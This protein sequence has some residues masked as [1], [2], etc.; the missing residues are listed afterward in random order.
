MQMLVK[1]FNRLHSIIRPAQFG[2]PKLSKIT[3]LQLPMGSIYHYHQFAVREVGPEQ[4]DPIIAKQEKLS[5]IN[6]VQ[7]LEADNARGMPIRVPGDIKQRYIQ[8][9]RENKRIRKLLDERIVEKNPRTLFIENYAIL[10]QLWRY[11]TT[12]LS[13]YDKLYNV[14]N[15]VFSQMGR[16]CVR[17]NRQ[18]Y[19]CIALPNSLPSIVSLRR[20]E[21]VRTKNSLTAFSTPERF[22]FA[23][24]FCWLGENR[25][26]SII[27]KIGLDGLRRANIVL[28]Y[29]D[30]FVN[31]NLGELNLWRKNEA[32]VGLYTPENMQRRLYKTAISIITSVD[33]SDIAEMAD[34]TDTDAEL[35]QQ[36]NVQEAAQ[37]VHG[38]YEDTPLVEQNITDQPNE[39]TFHEPSMADQ[40]MVAQE[41]DDG[42]VV[43]DIDEE[44]EFT[45]MV[46]DEPNDPNT[47]V[48]DN[49]NITIDPE[50]GIAKACEKFIQAGM[51]SVKEHQRITQ[52]ASAYKSI[53]NPYGEGVLADM[54]EV[55]PEET[56]IE[57][58]KLF[59]SEI[60]ID[61]TVLEATT[62]V[63]NKKYIENVLPKDVVSSVVSIQRAGVAVSNYSK[64][65]IVDATGAVEEHTVSLAPVNGQ[66]V[67]VRFTLPKLDDR[68]YWRANDVKYT[69]RRQQ[70]DIPIRKVDYNTVALTTFY[71]KN[72][73][74]RSEKVAYDWSSWL[75][76]QIVAQGI[77]PSNV[78]ITNISMG[79]VF[80]QTALLPHDYC[81]IARRVTTFKSAGISYSFDYK[82]L[83]M[84][85]KEEEI[86]ELKEISCVPIGRD[87]QS[88]YG[89]DMLNNVYRKTNEEV[90]TVGTIGEV[91]QL[92]LEKAP[93][94]Y[95]ELS[96]MGKAIPLGVIFGYYL[97][98]ENTFKLFNVPY[99]II[100]VTDRTPV[101]LDEFVIKTN[102]AKIVIQA[103]AGEGKLIVN[104]FGP[105]LKL[106]KNYTL[107]DLN[108][109][110]VYLNL[111]QK[112]GLTARYLNE[113][114]LMDQMYVDPISE[115]L[116][117]KIGEPTTFKG[118]L[119]RANE[120]LVND[121]SPEE[122]DMDYMHLYGM[123]RI[124]GAVY[125]EM[126]R[127]I[128]EYRNKPGT[129]KKLDL[130]PNA[131]WRAITT[132]GAVAPSSDA[133]PF[134]AI[135]EADVVTFG[136]TGGRSRRSMVKDTRKYHK[137][138]V[139][140]A[141]G[142]TVDSGDVGITYYLSSN[143]TLTDVDGM[144]VKTSE[145]KLNTNQY[146]SNTLLTAPGSLY[147]KHIV[148]CTSD[149]VV[150]TLWIA[151][152]C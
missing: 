83:G 1:Q 149:C 3:A 55:A 37:D 52:L 8:Y 78:N 152:T 71:G 107:R 40:E 32:K 143:P 29:Q 110:D 148:A 21:K 33:G 94:E 62:P 109:P 63:L 118:L 16:D 93:R 114:D 92:P 4:S 69:M 145:R 147:D 9:H 10:P 84:H 113:L 49:I 68:G 82:N 6:H 140:I 81:A 79:D 105:Y 130:P 146:L 124:P 47:L 75:A 141:S 72:F 12:E 73:I 65:D 11:R 2:T 15:T 119:K 19:I 126:V 142:D 14:Y 18:N 31:L 24:L 44:A 104:G 88:I 42:E 112:D 136:G 150:K 61:K 56:K 50:E 96:I 59:D 123:Q 115:R 58:V 60:I 48:V 30:R 95:T 43:L 46:A 76:G 25:E 132:D 64:R 100:E 35:S 138:S 91:L 128:R 5:V 117:K 67:T 54:L 80:D 28:T 111:I 7:V 86:A 34:V 26:N 38:D 70:V 120:L 116:L 53:P 45:T 151:G 129:R 103:G 139:G 131:V 98:I 66:P 17:F 97:G 36:G 22:L 102:D 87:K 135:K 23:E 144:P 57:P 74:C 106:I 77:D 108:T 121:Q 134:H 20:Y 85:F 41:E 122:T 137:S 13:W 27:N 90:V 101:Q 39:D 127:S 125:T 51:M 133:N 89:M 99:R